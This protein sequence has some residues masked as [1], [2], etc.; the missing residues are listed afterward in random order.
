MSLNLALDGQGRA[1]GSA[2]RPVQLSYVT[3][4]VFVAMVAVML[5]LVA[6]RVS[7]GQY[8]DADDYM[9]MVQA[10]DW[11]DGAGWY[12]VTQERLNP[13]AGVPMHW[14]RLPDLPLAAIVAASEPL[15]GQEAAITLAVTVVPPLILLAILGVLAWMGRIVLGRS[16]AELVPLMA[17]FAIGLWIQTLPGRVDHH[18]W[19]LLL[20]TAALACLIRALI[21]VRAHG[22]IALAAIASG[23]ALWVG[24]EGLPWLF[25]LSAVL[26]LRWVWLGRTALLAGVGFSGALVV[27][28]TVLL[29]LAQPPAQWFAVQCDGFTIVSLGLC[30]TLFVYWTGLLA[31]RGLPLERTPLRRA[32]TGLAWAAIAGGGFLLLFPECRGGPF[33]AVDPRVVSLWMSKVGEAAPL[34]PAE[35]MPSAHALMMLVSPLVGLAAAIWQFRKSHGRRRWAW[36]AVT[37]YL[38]LGL[39]LMFWQVR[40]YFFAHVFAILP[41][42]AMLRDGWERAG[43]LGH[44]VG[45]VAGKAV[46]LA[47][48]S[49]LPAVCL[50]LAV[51]EEPARA[52]PAAETAAANGDAEAE[53]PRRCS[54]TGLAASLAPL[55]PEPG[56]PLTIAGMV[57][58]G[59]EILLRTRGTG[60]G[61]LAAPYHRNRDGILD[62]MDLYHAADAAT[63]RDI[64]ARRGVDVLVLCPRISEM[65]L[66]DPADSVAARLAEGWEP[67]WL[68]PVPAPADSGLLIFRLVLSPESGQPGLS[69]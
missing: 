58:L 31:M 38:A 1:G 19:Q 22:F 37:V 54:L 33:S 36:L 10:L 24:A 9:R 17:L 6:G 45:R 48:L 61:V 51:A 46:W 15:I 34:I 62:A 57:D 13:P 3:V 64:A 40:V 65:S 49:P 21:G 35:G 26:W 50:A 29:A 32:A 14:S 11:L 43:R 44:P 60:D 67:A 28:T 47:L 56:E 7:Q 20:A 59:S 12:D 41:L 8:W 68:R 18:G 30:L 23:L 42:A 27:A 63:A 25:A 66:Y 53:E 4:G 69:R 55:R 2:S 5:A 39:A 16:H 52:A